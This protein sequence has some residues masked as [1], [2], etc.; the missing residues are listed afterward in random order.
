MISIH[1]S[2]NVYAHRND[3]IDGYLSNESGYFSLVSKCLHH[4]IEGWV[5]LHTMIII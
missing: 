1:L 3:E 2:H 4:D 5:P